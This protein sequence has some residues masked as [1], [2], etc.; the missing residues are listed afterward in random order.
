M[1]TY[2]YLIAILIMFM[3]IYEGI[4]TSFTYAP[5]KIK[6]ITIIAMV[7]VLLRFSTLL[8]LFLYDKMQY[9][10]LLKPLIFLEL[11]YMPIIIFICT[12]IYSRNDKIKLSFFYLLCGIFV[13]VYFFLIIKA[14]LITNI[15]A[16]YGYSITLKN[17]L[18]SYLVLLFI[19]TFVFILGFRVYSFKYSNKLGVTMTMV[20]ALVTIIATIISVLHADFVGAI[21]AGEIC[22]MATLDYGLRKFIR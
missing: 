22:W 17:G 18:N 15:S 16:I 7:L 3:L 20:A 10:Y 13:I 12:Y 4:T 2:I 6:A 19:N 21:I 11:F 8:L 9:V 14:P 5:T 1:F